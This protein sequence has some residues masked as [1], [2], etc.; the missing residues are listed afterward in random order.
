MET[1]SCR[2]NIGGL[3]EMSELRTA[4]RDL[5]K[6]LDATAKAAEKYLA[7]ATAAGRES[8]DPTARGLDGRQVRRRIQEQVIAQLSPRPIH[9]MPDPPIQLHG[10]P[11]ARKF[12]QLNP[13]PGL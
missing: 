6:A 2:P 7:A 3:V 9:G 12:V 8:E 13:L 4:A 11:G 5:V 10:A 1:A